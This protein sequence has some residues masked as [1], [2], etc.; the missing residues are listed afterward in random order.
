MPLRNQVVMSILIGSGFNKESRNEMR[1]SVATIALF[2][3]A[4]VCFSQVKTNHESDITEASKNKRDVLNGFDPI[5]QSVNS[6]KSAPY[7]DTQMPSSRR[8]ADL[9]QRL[10]F[11]EKLLLT[12]GWKGFN[13]TGIPRLGIRPVTMADASQGVR[14]GT[15]AVEGKSTSFPGM[16]PLASTWNNE[17]AG[18]FGKNIGEECRALGVDILL[19]PGIN[20]QRLSVGG[21][22]FEYMG[23][24]PLLTA[25]IATAYIRG[26][27]STGIIPTA[28]HFIGNDQEFCRH[29][30]NSVIGE[31]ALRE[32]YLRPWE[33][34]IKNANCMGIMTG[35]NL[36]NGIPCA[37]HKPLIADILRKEFGFTSLAM[38][39]WQ[40]TNYYPEKQNLVL[41]SGETLLMPENTTF[42]KWVN[43][44][45]ADD[46]ETRAK[47]ER[48]LE[49]MIFPT[50]EILFRMGVYD[51]E[52][53]DKQY[54][55][56]YPQ[57]QN[58]AR[59]CAEEAIVMLKNDADILPVDRN[60]NIV[61]VGEPEIHSGSGSGFVAGYDHV[62]YEAGLRKAYGE[63][64][65]YCEKI[66]EPVVKNAD[67]VIFNFNKNSGEGYD[68]PFD[69]P[70][71]VIGDLNAVLKLNKN[72][73]VLMNAANTMPME[74]VKDIKGLLWCSYLGQERGNA[75]AS[76][77]SGKVSPSGKLPFTIEKDFADSPDPDFNHIAGNPVWYGNNEYKEYWLGMAEKFDESFSKHI[78]PHQTIDV[79]YDEG[80]F[81]G[82]RW[83]ESKNKPVRFPFGFGLSY[84]QFHYSD[85][86]CEDHWAKNGEV[87]L[88]ATISNT[89]KQE[90]RE[91]VQL[92]VSDKQSSVPRPLKELKGYQ[93]VNLKPG[94]TKTLSF[95]LTKDA[96]SFWNEQA[97]SWVV[98]P[99]VFDVM[100]GASSADIRVKTTLDLK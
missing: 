21:R 80:V 93:K 50:I 20:M 66:D 59:E 77:V 39:D 12:G 95:V 55:D 91:I 24:D 31:R 81:I 89:G 56:L 75:L 62:S 73:V 68:V 35:N 99:G 41:Q 40:N 4:N 86:R 33:A 74:W 45:V 5:H 51:R 49:A 54:L 9:I 26:I 3:A 15:I 36:V 70:Q 63:R 2:L 87:I 38:T 64:F 19:G 10:T 58:L 17:L 14:L 76:I 53:Q 72:V 67:V 30:A 57:H 43:Q 78:K 29:I 100:L 28:K 22:N 47:I 84:T 48:Q 82:Y 71:A 94:E 88:S 65:T 23:E 52:P 8:A 1:R 92:Y 98:E 42:A 27:Q 60:K 79:P 34:I 61:L 96:F 18:R 13:I 97:H 69:N 32:I 44:Q 7:A 37:M 85:P 46:P 11:E 25:G 90:A 16:L 6:I 83:Y